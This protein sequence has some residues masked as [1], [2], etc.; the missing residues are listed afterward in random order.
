MAK[1]KELSKDQII[2]A[3]SFLSTKE[4]IEVKEA[5]QKILDD[6]E[7]FHEDELEMLQKGKPRLSN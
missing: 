1:T 7:Q 5:T 2:E 3:I 4:Q 6:K